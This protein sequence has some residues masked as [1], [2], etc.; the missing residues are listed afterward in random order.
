MRYSYRLDF[1]LLTHRKR[2][3]FISKVNPPLSLSLFPRPSSNPKSS[4]N[5]FCIE[6]LFSYYSLYF[7]QLQISSSNK[8]VA[9][10]LRGSAKLWTSRNSTFP[11]YSISKIKDIQIQKHQ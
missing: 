2:N 7:L 1:L 5:I 6:V 4:Q 9:E 8:K 11:A 10:I 3:F